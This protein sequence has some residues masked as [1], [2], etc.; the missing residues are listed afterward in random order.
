MKPFKSFILT[1]I[2]LIIAA[3]ASAGVNNSGVGTS[4]FNFLKIEVAARPTAMGGAFTGVA[5]DEGSLFY[6]P[7]GTSGLAGRRFILGYHNTI[8]DMQSGFLGYMHPLD[9]SKEV[10]GFVNYLNYGDFIKTDDEG[11]EL[12]TFSGSDILFALGYATAINEY[13]RVGGT[14]KLIYEKISDFSA[15]GVAVDLSAKWT[16]KNGRTSFGLMIQNL[17]KQLSS[18]IED[19]EKD[20]LPLNF[21]GGFSSRLRGL[22]LLVAG[23]VILPTDNDIY[24]SLG[25]EY[26]NLKPLYLR[27]GWTS[28][29]SNYK[30]GTSKDDLS[31][32]SGGFGI[33]YKRM[34]ISYAIS[35]QAE[36][37][38]THRITLTGGFE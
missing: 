35:P 3:V 38:T 17:G 25:A 10:F 5:D 1:G 6:N 32:F 28:F 26:L 22:P 19:G 16:V 13:L 12:G 34:Q 15:T 21:R 20:A 31:G 8:F 37:G 27:I 36:L 33:E 18:F 23:D 30:T 4:S 29:G 9:S 24:F 2:L 14:A 7:A 11:V